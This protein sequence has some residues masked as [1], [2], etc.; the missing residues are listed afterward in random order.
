[1]QERIPV[2]IVGAGGAGLSMALLLRQ[3]G[4]DSLLIE[5]RPDVSCNRAH[6]L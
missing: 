4:I 3:Q 2:L 6:A 5:R 1:M